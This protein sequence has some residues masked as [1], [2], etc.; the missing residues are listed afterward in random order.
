MPGV[1]RLKAPAALVLHLRFGIATVREATAL[2]DARSAG[3]VPVA[4]DTSAET[5]AQ[6]L[7]G[8]GLAGDRH[9][10]RCACCHG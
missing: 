4:L 3:L 5:I 10:M 7:V 9:V 1:A 2:R 8:A 6:P